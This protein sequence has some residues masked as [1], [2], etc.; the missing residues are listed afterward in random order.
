[1]L[2]ISKMGC[3]IKIKLVIAVGKR[4]ETFQ[5]L[6]FFPFLVGEHFEATSPEMANVLLTRLVSFLAHA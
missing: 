5:M 2:L 1:M 3:N 4:A 6:L